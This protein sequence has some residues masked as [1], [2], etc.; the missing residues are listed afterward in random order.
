MTT[1]LIDQ[2]AYAE[3]RSEFLKDF[4]KFRQ[5]EF[6]AGADALNHLTA[7][8]LVLPAARHAKKDKVKAKEFRD[9]MERLLFDMEA[10]QIQKTG[11]INF[12]GKVRVPILVSR[13]DELYL[14]LGDIMIECGYTR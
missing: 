11:E 14:T 7:M 13:L 3:Q 1:T 9:D 12:G 10:F 2:T 6:K 8:Y 4:F 5:G